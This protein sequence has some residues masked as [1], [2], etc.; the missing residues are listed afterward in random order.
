MVDLPI[1]DFGFRIWDLGFGKWDF[2]F[3]ISDLGNGIS[4]FGFRISDLGFGIHSRF[5]PKPDAHPAAPP[6][7][8]ILNVFNMK[9]TIRF[10]RVDGVPTR[11]TPRTINVCLRLDF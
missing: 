9:N 7:G 1:Y 5:H 3:R 4:D 8:E 6:H 11:L 10:L 2:G